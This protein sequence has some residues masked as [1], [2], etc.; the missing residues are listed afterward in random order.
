QIRI[1]VDN[2]YS[3]PISNFLD[4]DFD[5]L[6]PETQK[7]LTS[8]YLLADENQ[9]GHLEPLEIINNDAMGILYSA[10]I[11]VIDDTADGSLG[12]SIMHHKFVIIDRSRVLTGSANFTH[13]DFFGDLDSIKSRGNA[14]SLMLVE[15]E[16]FAD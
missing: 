1:V 2:Q 3:K 14:N 6:S 7:R 8:F 9:N 12:S 16:E 10:E 4:A 11:P 5:S 13:S 15:S